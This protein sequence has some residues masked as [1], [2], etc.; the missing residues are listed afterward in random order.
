LFIAFSFFCCCYRKVIPI[1]AVRQCAIRDLDT[2]GWNAEEVA[3][4]DNAPLSVGGGGESAATGD[5][6]SASGNR[7]SIY[8]TEAVVLV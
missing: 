3:P 6:F 2:V 7:Y 4:L 5:G 8:S 1:K